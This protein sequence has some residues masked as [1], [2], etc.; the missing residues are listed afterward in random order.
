MPS[1]SA[2]DRAAAAAGVMPLATIASAPSAAAATAS[3]CAA[4]KSAAR[5]GRS[6]GA[7]STC[8]WCSNWRTDGPAG[9]SGMPTRASSSVNS[10]SG[11]AHTRTSAPS[12][13]NCTASPTNGWTSP[14]DPYVD[15]T[16]RT[17]RLPLPQALAQ[18]DDFA[19]RPGACR[20]PPSARYNYSGREWRPSLLS[21]LSSAV[22]G[23]PPREAVDPHWSGGAG[24]VGLT[25]GDAPAILTARLGPKAPGAATVA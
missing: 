23:Q 5:R 10:S 18:A 1:F 25:P 21:P 9:T 24:N 15:N 7:P 2:T 20:K 12:A 3:N 17:S 14:R 8:T 11:G 19:A 4:T 22:D 13:R 16:T 6:G